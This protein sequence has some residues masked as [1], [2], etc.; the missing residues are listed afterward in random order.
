MVELLLYHA[1]EASSS[2]SAV[3]AGL[4]TVKRIPIVRET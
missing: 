3:Q 4:W 1:V 2:C